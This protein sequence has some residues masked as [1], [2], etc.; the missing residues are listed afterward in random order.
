MN[1]IKKK[2]WNLDRK[3]IY[4]L[5]IA[6]NTYLYASEIFYIFTYYVHFCLLKFPINA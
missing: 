4:L 2:K 1:V 6:R 3:S 5:N